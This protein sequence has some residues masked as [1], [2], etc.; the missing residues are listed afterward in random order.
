MLRQARLL[1]QQHCHVDAALPIQR[2]GA[3]LDEFFDQVGIRRCPQRHCTPKALYLALDVAKGLSAKR[4]SQNLDPA[5]EQGKVRPQEALDGFFDRRRR[6]HLEFHNQIE[7]SPQCWIDQLWVIGGS[8][9]QSR[10]RPLVNLLQDH[11][12]QPLEFTDVR[13]I[14]AAFG[15]CIDLVQQQDTGTTFGEIQRRAQVAATASQQAAHHGGQIEHVQRHAQLGRQPASRQRLAHPGLTNK[16][17]RAGRGQTE[18]GETRCLLA[19]LDQLPKGLFQLGRQQRSLTIRGVLEYLQQRQA[20]FV[21]HR[22]HLLRQR[23]RC[24]LAQRC[25]CPMRLGTKEQIHL[26]G[27]LRL[28]ASVLSDQPRSKQTH[29]LRLLGERQSNNLG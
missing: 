26:F 5:T 12:H 27:Q 13:V 19:L 20:R 15:D 9:Q 18:R 3:C 8:Q 14:A 22:Q 25:P 6:W 7:P 2:E 10:C 4:E 28:S 29:V 24:H 21:I 23:R 1:C 17:G 11:G 16:D